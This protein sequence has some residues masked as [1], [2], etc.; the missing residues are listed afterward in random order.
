MTISQASAIIALAISTIWHWPMLRSATFASGLTGT[1]SSASTARARRR[2]SPRSRR[3]LCPEGEI[4]RDAQVGNQAEMLVNHRD[5][6]GPAV[7]G[8]GQPQGATVDP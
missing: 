3:A 6:R 5:A 4:L 8:T 2:I 7:A 1:C